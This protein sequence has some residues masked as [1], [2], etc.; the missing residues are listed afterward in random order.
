MTAQH[1]GFQDVFNPEAGRKQIIDFP[2]MNKDC[3]E[4]KL[5]YETLNHLKI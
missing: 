5:T 2:P 3:K 4:H 1:M